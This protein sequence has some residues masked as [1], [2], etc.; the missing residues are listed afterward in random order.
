V[1]V[2]A[3]HIQTSEA[4]GAAEGVRREGGV[5]TVPVEEGVVVGRGEGVVDSVDLLQL[6][7]QPHQEVGGLHVT[8]EEV[9]VVQELEG[10]Q[11]L[12]GDH[13][14]GLERETAAA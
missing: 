6:L 13:Q 9:L 11:D 3:Q 8:V 5:G 1:T 14:D 12:V 2:S 10:R 7:P 4:E